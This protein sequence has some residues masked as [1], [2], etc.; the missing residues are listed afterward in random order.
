[1]VAPLVATLGLAR[2]IGLEGVLAKT[3]GRSVMAVADAGSGFVRCFAG[4]PL[5]ARTVFCFFTRRCPL[6]TGP[7][8]LAGSASSRRTGSLR[9]VCQCYG[10]KIYTVFT[11]TYP[12]V[13]I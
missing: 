10:T 12:V 1:M 11:F 4:F 6:A 5:R 13:C 9:R 7:L 2:W 3:V 8:V